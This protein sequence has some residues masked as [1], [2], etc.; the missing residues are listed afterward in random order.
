MGRQVR[1]SDMAVISFVLPL[2][3]QERRILHAE[4]GTFDA[5]SHGPPRELITCP[6][7]HWESSVA[8]Q[9]IRRTLFNAGQSL[10]V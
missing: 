5:A 2:R 1:K 6:E 9:A 8:S 4:T 7:T 3:H 10:S